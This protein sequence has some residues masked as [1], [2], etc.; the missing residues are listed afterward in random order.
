MNKLKWWL[1]IVGAFYVLLGGVNV[2]GALFD[3]QLVTA[4]YGA[5]TDELAIRVIAETTLIV[6]L[7][8]AVL[9]VMMFIA[10][11]APGGARFFVLAI[12]ML[13]LF[14]WVPYDV[15]TLLNETM[16]ASVVIPFLVLHLIF[17]IT[18]I[19]FLRQTAAQSAAKGN[20]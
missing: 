14:Q 7:G 20:A 2:Y 8:M 12:A 6:G 19:M 1:W 15:V 3:P 17:G 18:G 16:P 4:Y 5:I 9:G 11:R 13:E 10:S